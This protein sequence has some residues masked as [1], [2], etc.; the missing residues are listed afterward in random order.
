MTGLPVPP[1]VAKWKPEWDPG[2]GIHLILHPP[3]PYVGPT[4]SLFKKFM[5]K[6][7]ISHARAP[8]RGHSDPWACGV[9]A[10]YCCEKNCCGRTERVPTDVHVLDRVV[11]STV[12]FARDA[13]AHGL[14]Q[15]L[16]GVFPGDVID[17]ALHH[18]RGR[19]ARFRSQRFDIIWHNRMGK[20]D[21]V[22]DIGE[23]RSAPKDADNATSD[24]IV[25]YAAPRRLAVRFERRVPERPKSLP[26]S[27]M[28][29]GAV[30]E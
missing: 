22:C 26:E 18:A 4:I 21:V 16:V 11:A 7:I 1:V 8:E 9:S 23:V 15:E 19:R 24:W 10:K 20:A 28:H 13:R 29:I 2:D 5:N 14:D 17:E 27:R 25:K 6:V 12:S 3:V 30:L